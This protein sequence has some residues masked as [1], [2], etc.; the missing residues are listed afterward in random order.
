[1]ALNGDAASPTTT[2]S[3]TTAAT[4][5]IPADLDAVHKRKREDGI[6]NSNTSTLR[7]E[8]FQ[9]DLLQVLE[10]YAHQ[11]FPCPPRN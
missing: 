9:A 1:M 10:R 11:L 4:N 2:T 3:T 8:Q 5:N 7:D 6:A